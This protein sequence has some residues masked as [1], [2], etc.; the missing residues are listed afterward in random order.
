MPNFALLH[1]RDY[2]REVSLVLFDLL[3]FNGIDVR[4]EPLLDRKGR[5][6]RLLSKVKDGIEL[7]AHLE[8]DGHAIFEHACK[9]G[10][11]GAVAKRIDLGYESGRSKRWLKIKNPTAR[12]H[13]G[14]RMVRF[15]FSRNVR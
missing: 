10:H 11:K 9:L 7:N 14:L 12:P 4:R 15:E 8:G 2:D 1:S 3:E 5:L 13:V 6:K